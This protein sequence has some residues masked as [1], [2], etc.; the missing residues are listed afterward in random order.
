MKRPKT[1]ICN[2]CG[3][4]TLGRQWW[5]RDT[6]FGLCAEC[7]NETIKR[8][9]DTLEGV[10]FSSGKRGIH[11]DLDYKPML[12]LKVWV[13]QFMARF[14]KRELD[15]MLVHKAVIDLQIKDPETGG[16]QLHHLEY[17]SKDAE[18]LKIGA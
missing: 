7:G 2:C 13:E 16:I 9:S 5:N 8:S 10:E 11:W 6:G 15:Y 14:D 1:L 18:N 12:T 3:K 17:I 4:A